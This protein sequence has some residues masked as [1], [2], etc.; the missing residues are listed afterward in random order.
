MKDTRR[1]LLAIGLMTVAACSAKAIADDRVPPGVDPKAD[2]VLRAMGDCLAAAQQLSFEATQM[3]DE[4]VE[5]GQKLQFSSVRKIAMRRPNLAMA[6]HTGDLVNHRTYYDGKTLT[7]I[8]DTNKVYSRI[9]APDTIDAMLDDFA[10]RYAATMPLGDLLLS[11]PYQMVIGGV[12]SGYYVG[13]NSVFDQKC[14]HLAFRQDAIDW[15]IWIQAEGDPVP[16]KLVITYKALPGQPQYVAFLSGWNLKASLSDDAFSTSIPDG[17]S[18]V[19]LQAV[20]ANRDSAIDSPNEQQDSA[21][22][23]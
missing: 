12:R 1:M 8:D 9:D 11:D 10:E 14:H 18:E 4:V 19:P 5:S 6:T 7:L 3:I 22:H 23:D 21:K 15:Q 16:R 17:F 13:L 20:A 2:R